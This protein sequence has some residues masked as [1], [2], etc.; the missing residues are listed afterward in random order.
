[1]TGQVRLAPLADEH[2]DDVAAMV[3]DPDVVRFT[4]AFF[5]ELRRYG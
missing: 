2:L 1:V 3:A 4:R 5:H